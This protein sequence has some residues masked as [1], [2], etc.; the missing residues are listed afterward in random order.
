M[1]LNHY[2]IGKILSSKKKKATINLLKNEL[3]Y[4]TLCEVAEIISKQSKSF[5]FSFFGTT[6]PETIEELGDGNKVFKP[7]SIENEIK[8]SFLS[9]RDN[10]TKISLFL[11]LK[12]DF[13]RLFLL[14]KYD[15]AFE[16]LELI[17]KETGVS[18]WYIETK[19]LLLEYL[20]S[21][22]SQKEL[23]SEINQI[24]KRGLIS[25][26][27]H[28]LSQR[29]ERNLSAFKYDYDLKMLFEKNK[30][31][32]DSDVKDYYLFRLNYFEHYNLT[33]YTSAVVFENFNSVIDRYLVV[34]NVL[35]AMYLKESNRDFVYS[36]ARYLHRK[37]GDKQLLPILVAYNPKGIPKEYID[38]NYI[39]ILDLYYSGLY[40]ET[41]NECLNFLPNNN[42][43]FDLII[44][45]CRCHINLKKEFTNISEE[46]NSLLNQMANKTYNLLYNKGDANDLLYNIYQISK[47]INSFDLTAGL[48]F[49]IKKEQKQNPNKTLKLLHHECFDPLFTEILSEENKAKD[50]LE[51]GK[52]Y[53]SG[54][55]V[56]K[57]HINKLNNQLIEDN[58]LSAEILEIDNAK[59]LF[60]QKRYIESIDNWKDIVKKFKNNNPII[61]TALKYW[62]ECLVNLEKYDE[63]IVM[64]VDAYIENENSTNKINAK[65]LISKLRNFRYKGIERSID[66]PIFITVN[67]EDDTEKSF[68]LEQFCRMFSKQ[69]PSELFGYN[70]NNN[71]KKIESFYY[72]VCNQDT[73]K[74]S[75]FI[76]NTIDKLTERLNIVNH[77]L[78]KYLANKKIYQEELNLISNELIIYEGTQKLDESKIYAN[79]QAIINS[80]IKD[81]DGLFNRYKTIYRLS[82]K[83]KKLLVISDK[84]YAL[85]NFNS[86]ES[87]YNETEVKYTDGA[88]LE[89]FI[90]LFDVILEKFLF[91]KFGIVAY[92]STRIRHGVLLGELR[93]EIDK[94]NLI[95]NRIGNTNDY[96]QSRFWNTQLFGLDSS[97]KN[98]LHEILKKFSLSVDMLIEEI[99]KDRIQIKK[100]GKNEKG[101]F[102]YE[103]DRIEMGGIAYE[104]AIE[105]DAKVFCQKVIDFLWQRTDAN[106]EVIRSFLENDIKDTFA[107]L[108]NTLE[109]DLKISIGQ[110]SLPKIYTNINECSTILENKMDKISSWFRR[111]GSKI[112]DFD[113][114][115]LFNIVWNNTLKCYPKLDVECKVDQ[116]ANPIIRSEFYIHF[117]DLFRIFLDNMLKYGGS[118]K[119]KKFFDFSCSTE[120]SFL[121]CR[122]TNI[123]NEN[124]AELPY[125]TKQDQQVID[126]EKLISEGKSGYYKA[127]KI[128]KYDLNNENNSIKIPLDDPEKF[129]TIVSIDITNLTKDETIISS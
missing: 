126:T 53:I 25:T 13:E 14:A 48:N 44:I 119:G 4:K 56:I 17:K 105:D 15:K 41:I 100:D 88:L 78:E 10:I 57:H 20:N 38:L 86:T 115:K 61:Q 114:I 103:F 121:V 39:K 125:I 50:Y 28:F 124:F 58:N 70:L 82:L 45:Y 35:K 33:D 90:E 91:S 47:N 128:V 112:D 34:R 21:S 122:F 63:A 26:L 101:L 37:T 80:E 123:K 107:N 68:V 81:I 11:V 52:E 22:D 29:A 40:E 8:W 94:Q 24:N 65:G 110:N 18:L 129:I 6:T 60:K 23:V 62:F 1:S 71:E 64:F 74:H 83:G 76:D 120:G 72:L 127:I 69:K 108:L 9:I 55:I 85:Y 32:I 49:F 116:S 75:I 36:R 59:I 66:L 31:E 51:K 102:N 106:L 113:I 99:I 7:K 104:L 12:A 16:I 54:S 46:H 84:S 96:E 67:S 77:L 2:A 73:L 89:V 3:D 117:T 92:L 5:K 109:N 79:D 93:P 43:H 95:L 97:T 98:K 30:K 111:S 27:S 19:F 87:S 42:F 118:K